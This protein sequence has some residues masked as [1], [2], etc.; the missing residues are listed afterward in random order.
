MKPET[1]LLATQISI[2]E[3]EWEQLVEECR[4]DECLALA[5]RMYYL[6][7]LTSTHPFDY[8]V[9]EKIYDRGRPDVI[10]DYMARAQWLADMLRQI[11][12]NDTNVYFRAA[13]L[14]GAFNQT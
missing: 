7:N 9:P 2:N 14:A 6:T 1:K 13:Q 10:V 11:T 5:A 12:P 3:Q 4:R 8:Y